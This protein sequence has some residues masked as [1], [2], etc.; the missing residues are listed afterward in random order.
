MRIIG[1][2]FC[3]RGIKFSTDLFPLENLYTQCRSTSAKGK[4]KLISSLHV[5]LKDLEKVQQDSSAGPAEKTLKIQEL[6]QKIEEV[7]M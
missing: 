7:Q 2:C 1:G 3:E 4:R 5:A 6:K